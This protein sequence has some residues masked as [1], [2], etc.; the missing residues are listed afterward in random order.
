MLILPKQ[1]FCYKRF[2]PWMMIRLLF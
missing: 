2:M 1:S